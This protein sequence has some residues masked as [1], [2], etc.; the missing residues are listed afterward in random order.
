MLPIPNWLL[1]ERVLAHLIG[2]GTAATLGTA[3]VLVPLLRTAG[4]A[5]WPDMV[6]D[7]VVTVLGT[8]LVYGPA[9]AVLGLAMLL[10]VRTTAE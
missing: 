5:T 10:H 8:T 3:W 6:Q 1:R 2:A 7:I 4:I 9:I